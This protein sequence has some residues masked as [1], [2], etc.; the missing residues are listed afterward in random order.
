M[1]RSLGLAGAEGGGESEQLLQGHGTLFRGEDTFWNWIEV[2]LEQ[3]YCCIKCH[4]IV[5]FYL[6][7]C[8]FERERK[9]KR[10]VF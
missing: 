10:E 3:N 1:A 8:S 4:W 7:V 9:T 5:H 2:V 6:F